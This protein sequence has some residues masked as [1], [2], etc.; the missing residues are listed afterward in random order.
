MIRDRVFEIIA[1]DFPNL[2]KEEINLARMDELIASSRYPSDVDQF[3]FV[4]YKAILQSTAANLTRVFI[5]EYSKLELLTWGEDGQRIEDDF[6]IRI[7]SRYER[8]APLNSSSGVNSIR[9]A[10]A[11]FKAWSNQKI[12]GGVLSILMVSS[13]ALTEGD[14]SANTRSRLGFA[15]GFLFTTNTIKG[16]AANF[17]LYS[18]LLEKVNSTWSKLPMPSIKIPV[19]LKNFVG[20][21]LLG[22]ASAMMPHLSK[23]AGKLVKLVSIGNAAMVMAVAV[24]IVDAVRN[25]GEWNDQQRGLSVVGTTAMFMNTV[26]GASLAFIAIPGASIIMAIGFAVALVVAIVMAVLGVAKDIKPSNDHPSVKYYNSE[27]HPDRSYWKWCDERSDEKENCEQTVSA[28]IN[29]RGTIYQ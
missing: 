27:I 4:S 15:T 13:L 17:K 14:V 16:F 25:W 6:M 22:K 19:A 7:E 26:I 28:S 3:Y 11:V 12:M 10:L 5:E 1:D 29:L 20:Q 21:N 18:V 2:L 8:E 23:L 9:R 24:Q